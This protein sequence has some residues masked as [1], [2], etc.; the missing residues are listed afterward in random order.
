[1]EPTFHRIDHPDFLRPLTDS[2]GNSGLVQ[3]ARRAYALDKMN[4]FVEG[5]DNQVPTAEMWHTPRVGTTP[6]LGNPRLDTCSRIALS[7]VSDAQ[8]LG[9]P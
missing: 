7:P 6:T 5:N 8:I 3:M 9:S 1:M 4:Y 2:A